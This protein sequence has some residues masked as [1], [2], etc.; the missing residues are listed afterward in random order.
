ML[1]FRKESNIDSLKTFYCLTLPSR[2]TSS[3]LKTFYWLVCYV[4]YY[5]YVN[6]LLVLTNFLYWYLMLVTYD[7]LL[8]FYISNESN[9]QVMLGVT[10]GSE[11]F[12]NRRNRTAKKEILCAFRFNYLLM[13]IAWKFQLKNQLSIYPEISRNYPNINFHY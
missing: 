10:S 9:E 8:K 3:K 1:I 11:L 12:W 13:N 2:L 6:R 5:A 4:N 7:W